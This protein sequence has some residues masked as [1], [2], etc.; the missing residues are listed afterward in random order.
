HEVAEAVTAWRD[1]LA[2]RACQRTLGVGWPC[3][4]GKFLVRDAFCPSSCVPRRLGIAKQ[5]GAC[6]GR[7]EASSL[8][9]PKPAA[10]MTAHAG[11]RGADGIDTSA[12]RG[13]QRSTG[14]VATDLVDLAAFLDQ[15]GGGC[16]CRCLGDGNR[17]DDAGQKQCED[18]TQRSDG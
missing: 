8:E 18:G 4:E 6:D 10:L 15:I 5:G 1:A 13:A 11:C 3:Q 17:G 7:Y 14:A 9:K 2:Q 12:T 16:L